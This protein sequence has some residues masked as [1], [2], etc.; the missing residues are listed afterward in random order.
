MKNMYFSYNGFKF[1]RITKKTAKACFRT[2]FDV[3]FCPVNLRPFT[4]YHFE[5][6]I[7]AARVNDGFENVVNAFEYYNCI[8]SETG[9]YTAFY[10]PVKM[11]DMFTGEDPT[12]DTLHRCET[13]DKNFMEVK[14]K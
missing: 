10:I 3:V 12:P 2:G 8:N 13:Y 14:T 6:V 4:M 7:N 9:K 5:S 11:I 1:K